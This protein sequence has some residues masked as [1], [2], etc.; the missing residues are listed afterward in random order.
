MQTTYTI[1]VNYDGEQDG[2]NWHSPEDQEATTISF[3][4][5]IVPGL[6]DAYDSGVSVVSA[7][8]V[9]SSGTVDLTEPA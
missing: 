4:K 7:E 3:M 2:E 8:A 5:A 6:A 9:S 1:V